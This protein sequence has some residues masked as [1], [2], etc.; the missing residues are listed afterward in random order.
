ML[1]IFALILQI[2]RCVFLIVFLCHYTT[3]VPRDFQ[4]NLLL[5]CDFE[6]LKYTDRLIMTST[7]LEFLKTISLR[8][9]SLIEK[10]T[11]LELSRF[12]LSTVLHNS[13]R[14]LDKIHLL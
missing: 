11:L 5:F 13:V 9:Y 6:M 12:L 2:P 8:D 1:R 3:I 7:S 4:I 14:E 10:E